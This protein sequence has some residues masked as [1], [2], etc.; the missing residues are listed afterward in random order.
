RSGQNELALDL[1]RGNAESMNSRRNRA[2]KLKKRIE[3]TI[4]RVQSFQYFHERAMRLKQK[5]STP[6]IKP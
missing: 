4:R 6:S 2:R 1:V 3:E 5:Q